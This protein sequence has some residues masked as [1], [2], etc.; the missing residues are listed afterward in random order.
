MNH[1]KLELRVLADISNR[2]W[3]YATTILSRLHVVIVGNK[4][5][6]NFK[7]KVSYVV[8][9][10]AVIFKDGT[11]ILAHVQIL[12]FSAWLPSI[13]LSGSFGEFA[14]AKSS[15]PK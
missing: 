5:Q 14:T 1:E 6:R 7:L 2:F 15:Y 10:F 8:Q 9:T 12:F 11:L 13:K 4:T 3:M